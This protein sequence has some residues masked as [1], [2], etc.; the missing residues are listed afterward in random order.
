LSKAIVNLVDGL[1]L[2]NPAAQLVVTTD[3]TFIL[4][5]EKG[6]GFRAVVENT[7]K[8]PLENFLESTVTTTEELLEVN[9]SVIG[10]G[11]LGIALFGPAGMILGGMSG[12][13][14]KEKK[15]IQH[16]Y[17]ISYLSS[18][19]EVKNITF[20]M[21]S[22]MVSV[23]RNFDNELKKVMKSVQRSEAAMR[24]FEDNPKNQSSGQEKLL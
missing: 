5:E 9:K 16:V 11:I 6:Q 14:K 17:I 12:I 10:R 13:G 3:G 20:E 2:K 24:I 23:T 19:G 21:P 18:S 22:M 15:K 7:F 8:I 1:P 4:I